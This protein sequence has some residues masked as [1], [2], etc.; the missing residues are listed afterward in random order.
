[1]INAIKI[2]NKLKNLKNKDY[3]IVVNNLLNK[4]IKTKTL[5]R[6]TNKN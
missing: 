4:P 5:K 2:K 1:M 3:I 6:N